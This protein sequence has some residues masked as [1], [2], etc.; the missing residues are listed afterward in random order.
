MT[1]FTSSAGIGTIYTKREEIVYNIFET[2]LDMLSEYNHL[3]TA[4]FS[5]GSL[6]SYKAIDSL[7]HPIVETYQWYLLVLVPLLCGA[8]L[9][10]KKRGL[11]SYIKKKS[12]VVKIDEIK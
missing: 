10:Y 4:A 9:V 6:F 7:G 8:W 12:V 3:S 11:T 1:N 5:F 2:E